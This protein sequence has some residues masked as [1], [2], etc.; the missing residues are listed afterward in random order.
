MDCPKCAAPHPAEAA[1]CSVCH[2]SFRPK[3]KSQAAAAD[4]PLMTPRVEAHIQDWVFVG[5]MVTTKEGLYIFIESSRREL[6]AGKRLWGTALGASTG[7]VAGAM[8]GSALDNV[9]AR[10]GRP[11]AVALAPVSDI[12]QIYVLCPVSADAPAA[13]DYFKVARGQ[14]RSVQMPDRDFLVVEG[15]G[16]TLEVHG[17]LGGALL[18]AHLRK[19]GYPIDDC[20]AS[21][22]KRRWLRALGWVAVL[23]AVA[24][25]IGEFYEARELAL[26]PFVQKLITGPDGRSLSVPAQYVLFCGGWGGIAWLCWK[27]FWVGHRAE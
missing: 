12:P 16:F 25:G 7:L 9:E 13:K 4:L 6:S 10:V 21:A 24:A 14:A 11:T 5:P 26:H 17:P 2:E 8:V 20:Q 23:A 15:T 18:S 19:W 22:K 1:A 27:A 3:N